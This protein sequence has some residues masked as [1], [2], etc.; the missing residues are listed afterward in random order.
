MAATTVQNI[1]DAAIASS[2]ANDQGRTILANNTAE[3]V[4]V[5]SR[6]VRMVYA[7]AALPPTDGGEGYG[8]FFT[9]SS[10]VTLASPS[11]DYVALPST[12]EF[13][14]FQNFVDNVG[15]P[16]AVVTL[17]DLRDGVAEYPP[18]VVIADGK[19]RSAGR[20]SDGD[21]AAGAVLTFD[22]S[23]LPPVL[24]SASDYIGATT[25][26]DSS[27]SA[28]P[29]DVG[30]PFLIAVLGRYLALKDGARD[31]QEIAA[32]DQAI[33]ESATRLAQV[34]GATVARFTDVRPAS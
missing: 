1:F 20:L 2:L 31:P 28:W 8:N 34:V 10:T 7:A 17:R 29:D 3:L 18:A 9:R 23:Y 30:N 5:V 6:T 26:A 4:G 32:Y 24:T 16:V 25:P 27:T 33:A 22:G 19:I 13:R 14:F 11:T 12:P 21:P 15:T